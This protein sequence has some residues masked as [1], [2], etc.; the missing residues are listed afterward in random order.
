M[1]HPIV[2]NKKIKTRKRRI[3]NLKFSRYKLE[4]QVPFVDHERIT[5]TFQKKWKYA[6]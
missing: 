6:F 3:Q 4:L 5:M 1:H 2:E